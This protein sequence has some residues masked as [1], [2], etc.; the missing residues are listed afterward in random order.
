MYSPAAAITI[1]FLKTRDFKL[2]D[3]QWLFEQNL[4]KKPEISD[5]LGATALPME[6]ARIA[7]S[8]MFASNSYYNRISENRKL[9]RIHE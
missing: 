5:Y 2:I 9:Q 6:F 3:E 7:F 8:I 1:K 4:K